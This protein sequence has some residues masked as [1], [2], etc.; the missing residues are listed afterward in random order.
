MVYGFQVV[1]DAADPP[2]LARFWQQALGYVE[3]APPQGYDSWDDFLVRNEIPESDRDRMGSAVPPDFDVATGGGSRPRLLFVRVPEGK[4]VKNRLHLD[5]AVGG[6]R[7][8]PR[9]ERWPRILARAAQLEELGATRVR[10]HEEPGSRWLVMAD[11]EGNEFCV[12]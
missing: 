11:P 7:S 4:T 6:D 5:I 1:F 9:Q 3:E 12:H 2:R 8:T 10:E